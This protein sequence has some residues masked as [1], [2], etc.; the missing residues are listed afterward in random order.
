MLRA[1]CGLV[2]LVVSMPA[3]AAPRS[4]LPETLTETT[5][6]CMACHAEENP[7]LY[8]QWGASKHYGANVGCYECHLANKTDGDWLRDGIHDDY[9][10]STIVSPLDCARCHAQETDESGPDR[11]CSLVSMTTAQPDTQA[12]YISEMLPS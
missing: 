7:G 3:F 9:V 12:L 6:E 5:R 10:I 1:I 11:I 8:Q 2:L 4:G